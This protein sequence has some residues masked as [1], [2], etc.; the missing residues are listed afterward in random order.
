MKRNTVLFA[1]LLAVGVAGCQVP[2]ERSSAPSAVSEA[3]MPAYC[4]GEASA[5]FGVRPQDLLTLPVERSA[6]GYSVYGQYPPE[7]S[8]VTTFECR[9]NGAGAFTGVNRT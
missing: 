4:R 5:A 7:G 3:D 1:S 2:E 9:F 8:D 6:N